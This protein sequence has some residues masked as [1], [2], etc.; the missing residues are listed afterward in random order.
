MTNL[1]LD[2]LLENLPGAV[3]QKIA[4]IEYSTEVKIKSN[5]EICPDCGS[6]VIIKGGCT[7]C[8]NCGSQLGGGCP[9]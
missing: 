2:Q 4:E 8:S 6:M 3:W 1:T 7:H 5:G 9:S